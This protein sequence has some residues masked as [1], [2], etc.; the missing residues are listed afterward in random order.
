MKSKIAE[1]ERDWGCGVINDDMERVM[2]ICDV[3]GGY[4]RS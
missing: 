2:E 4:H 1:G 3:K